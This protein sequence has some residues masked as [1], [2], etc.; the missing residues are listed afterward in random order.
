MI[1]CAPGAICPT[2][3]RLFVFPESFAI[4][5]ELP[6][7]VEHAEA[8][9]FAGQRLFGALAGWLNNRQLLVRRCS[10]QLGHDDAPPTV[11]VLNFA[12]PAADEGRFLRLLRE[13]LGRLQLPAPVE[14]LRLAADELVDKPGTSARLFGQ[15][16]A[17]EGTLACLERLRA[18]LGEGRCR[19]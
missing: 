4:A 3:K 16:Q 12:E 9:V 1:C 19:R 5:V 18:R 2:R 13:H 15:D 8:L 11:V 6:A 7:R 17:G 10:L 14:S